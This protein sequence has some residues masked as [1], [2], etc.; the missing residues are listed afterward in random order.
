MFYRDKPTLTD[1]MVRDNRVDITRIENNSN[2]AIIIDT[3]IANDNYLSS[4]ID[5]KKQECSEVCFELSEIWECNP[6]YSP[7]TLQSA[8]AFITHS[9]HSIAD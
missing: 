6:I 1:S 2:K 3:V 8:A 7:Q 5:S 4:A 9:G